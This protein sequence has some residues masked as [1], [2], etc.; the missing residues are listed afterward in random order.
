MWLGDIWQMLLYHWDIW[1][2]EFSFFLVISAFSWCFALI[3]A[4]AP[5]LGWS[6]YVEEDGGTWCSIDWLNKSGSNMSYIICIFLFCYIMPLLVIALSYC[7]IWCKLRQVGWTHKYAYLNSLIIL[8]N[9]YPVEFLESVVLESSA[10]PGLG[11]W[12][13]IAGLVWQQIC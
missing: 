12:T 7:K 4:G 6:R 3:W 5:L 10:K 1:F 8:L 13:G 9:S 11:C 2:N